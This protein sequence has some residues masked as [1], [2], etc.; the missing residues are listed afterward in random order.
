[1]LFVNKRPSSCDELTGVG[2]NHALTHIYE[3]I[4][5]SYDISAEQAK[6]IHDQVWFYTF[7]LAMHCVNQPL[8]EDD[9]KTL[10]SLQFR[11]VLSFVKAGKEKEI[12]K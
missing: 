5:N 11:S 4:A 9:I 1:M 8:S 12:L 10:L 2:E 7:G 6:L 3:L